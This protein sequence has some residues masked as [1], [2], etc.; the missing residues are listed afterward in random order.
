MTEAEMLE[1]AE[2]VA[3]NA[4][5]YQDKLAAQLDEA[6]EAISRSTGRADAWSVVGSL[7]ERYPEV[8]ELAVK[9]FALAT[10]HE[11]TNYEPGPELGT[12]KP[13]KGRAAAAGILAVRLMTPPAERPSKGEPLTVTLPMPFFDSDDISNATQRLHMTMCREVCELILRN[14]G[15]GARK[16]AIADVATRYGYRRSAVEQAYDTYRERIEPLAQL[17]LLRK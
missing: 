14:P 7:P 3:G 6:L 5:A 9:L 1:M 12:A 4:R 15:R 8:I 11:A 2:R 16:V 10:V 17:K 13:L